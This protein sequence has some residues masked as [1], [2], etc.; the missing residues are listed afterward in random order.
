MNIRSARKYTMISPAQLLRN[1]CEQRPSNQGGLDASVTEEFWIVCYMEMC[2]LLILFLHHSTKIKS[3]PGLFRSFVLKGTAGLMFR[4]CFISTVSVND[5]CCS[6][7]MVRLALPLRRS[8]IIT[9]IYMLWLV[10]GSM[11]VQSIWRAD[12]LSGGLSE[13]L[14][15]LDHIS[16]AL[17]VV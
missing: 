5:R 8:V 10:Y 9:P 12:I 13:Y 3:G 14:F 7:L 1:W 17:D 6:W 2:L 4:H 16:V 15:T 11:Q